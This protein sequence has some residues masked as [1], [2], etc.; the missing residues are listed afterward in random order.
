MAKRLLTDSR[1]SLEQI[2][3]QVGYDSAAAFS[4]VF[5]KLTGRAPG[6]WRQIGSAMA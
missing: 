1:L 6:A 3:A 4:R 2:A 5:K